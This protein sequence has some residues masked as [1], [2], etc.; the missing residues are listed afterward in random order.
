MNAYTVLRNALLTSKAGLIDRGKTPLQRETI[1]R[2]LTL[3]E[4]SVGAFIPDS[5]PAMRSVA[6]LHPSLRPA[7]DA[8]TQLSMADHD[9]ATAARH[10]EEAMRNYYIQLG[11]GNDAEALKFKRAAEEID[12][13]EGEGRLAPYAKADIPA[14]RAALQA[15][16]KPEDWNAVSGA[17]TKIADL[18]A[19]LLDVGSELLDPTQVAVYK[20]MAAKGIPYFRSAHERKGTFDNP[21]S[22]GEAVEVNLN[23]LE[24]NA[25]KA[26]GASRSSTDPIVQYLSGSGAPYEKPVEAQFENA[27]KFHKEAARQRLAKE[28]LDIMRELGT[29]VREIDSPEDITPLEGVI[30]YLDKGKTRRFAVAK[31]F[32]DAMNLAGEGEIK[33]AMG[34]LSTFQRFQSRAITAHNLG[35]ILRN[36]P[37]DFT[38]T[39]VFMKELEGPEDYLRFGILWAKHLAK[40]GQMTPERAEFFRAGGGLS[41]LQSQLSEVPLWKSYEQRGGLGSVVDYLGRVQGN[42]ELAPKVAAFEFMRKH[43]GMGADEAAFVAR[44][45]AGSPDFG[46]YGTRTAQ[47]NQLIQFW[48][49]Q[50]Q[51]LARLD[52]LRDPKILAKK[53]FVLSLGLMAVNKWNSQ[54][55]DEETGRPEIETIPWSERLNNI[56]IMAD[57][58]G[59]G[60]PTAKGR[61]QRTYL[62]IPLGHA[63]KLLLSPMMGIFSQADDEQFAQSG[64]E[65]GANVLSGLLPTNAN[66]D[67]DNP[68]KAFLSGVAGINPLLRWPLEQSLNR[69]AFLGVPIEGKRVENVLPEARYTADTMETAKLLSKGARALTGD[70]TWLA[71]PERMEHTIKTFLP[72]AF[73]TPVGVVEALLKKPS[74]SP[75]K[76]FSESMATNPVMGPLVRSLLPSGGDERRNQWSKGLYTAY[77]RTSDAAR[78][79]KK[80]VNEGQQ[81]KAMAFYQKHRNA[82]EYNKY[83]TR[84]V[85]DLSEIGQEEQRILTAQMSPEDKTTMM[86]RLYKLKLAKLRE[87]QPLVGMV[88]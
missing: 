83:L 60:D 77:D 13:R 34:V 82:I 55:I 20:D 15:S 44:R 25:L 70:A 62:K 12:L 86:G 47:F 11:R 42:L 17:H 26:R 9:Y 40:G 87:A 80:Y 73:E 81:E 68:G 45:Y 3:A 33:R 74:P 57:D 41:N 29:S 69:Y 58:F 22:P 43:K 66:I 84:I 78:T 38:D 52:R 28:S 8:L 35:F 59:K 24:N 65:I 6:E 79:F 10:R 30:S 53:M 54:F 67:P 36:V 4:N 16:L 46:R 63:A 21:M 61:T 14:K 76:T 2:R 5:D 50:V 23:E 27:Y 39:L 85:R 71:S 88:R 31:E 19:S 7:L 1:D 37:K 32:A 48:N 56:V 49:P 75:Q 64:K 18:N 72:G 51:G